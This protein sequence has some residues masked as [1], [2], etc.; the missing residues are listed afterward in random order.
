MTVAINRVIR[1]S[2]QSSQNLLGMIRIAIGYRTS[3][4]T[5]IKFSLSSDYRKSWKSPPIMLAGR[6]KKWV[7]EW[8][9][10]ISHRS[11]YWGGT[12]NR[13]TW[14]SRTTSLKVTGTQRI[15]LL[16]SSTAMLTFWSCSIIKA[17]T[18][19]VEIILLSPIQR[20]AMPPRT[21]FHEHVPRGSQSVPREPASHDVSFS[22]P[23]PATTHFCLEL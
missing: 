18:Y 2:L 4:I 17:G 14:V 1:S 10:P 11:R 6:E 9:E 7:R 19:E 23:P 13:K 5:N 12:E 21:D 15:K 16:T 20:T 22:E 3:V 8:W